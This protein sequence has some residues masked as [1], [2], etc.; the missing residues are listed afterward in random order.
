MCNK[1]ELNNSISTSLFTSLVSFVCGD[2]LLLFSKNTC[3]NYLMFGRY[4]SHFKYF[5]K[6]LKMVC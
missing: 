1:K 5:E 3:T 2:Y 4:I 6:I